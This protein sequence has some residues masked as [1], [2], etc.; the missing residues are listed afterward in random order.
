[1]ILTGLFRFVFFFY[2]YSKQC[3]KLLWLFPLQ[4]EMY[5]AMTEVKIFNKY[6]FGNEIIFILHQIHF[7]RTIWNMENYTFIQNTLYKVF[8]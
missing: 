8:H 2:K 7:V 5:L 1:M 3:C 4:Y 6:Y